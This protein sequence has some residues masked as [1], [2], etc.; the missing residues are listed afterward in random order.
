MNCGYNVH[1][2]RSDVCPECGQEYYLAVGVFHEAGRFNA[3]AATLAD[4]GIEFRQVSLASP[5]EVMNQLMGAG[6]S[7]A[8]FGAAALFVK[9]NDWPVAKEIIAAMRPLP[10]VDRS[11]PIC[12]KCSAELDLNGT[13]QCSRCG[14]EFQ[15][16]E[17]EEPVI[18]PTGR[19]C[20][21]CGYELTGNLA[22]GR[23][24]ECGAALPAD[25]LA[26]AAMTE[27]QRA[28]GP[29]EDQPQQGRIAIPRFL[30]VLLLVLFV[31]IVAF[32]LASEEFE[33]LQVV[34]LAACTAVAAYFINKYARQPRR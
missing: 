10:I 14:T 1:G 23:C 18:D 22:A 17:I 9:R 34:L 32:L 11:E 6:G 24:P 26:N 3:A 7:T 2:V 4:E 21:K 13:E 29:P 33:I 19:A 5:R 8:N 16:V 12:P 28:Q 31:A 15:W 30:D 20:H 25:V 27:L